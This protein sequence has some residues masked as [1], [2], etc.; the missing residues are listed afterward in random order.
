MKVFPL[1]SISQLRGIVRSEDYTRYIELFQST[2]TT[3][4]ETMKALHVVQAGKVRQD[5][6][7]TRS[8]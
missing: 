4:K 8:R 6:L 3:W 5:P 2:A 1:Q 7:S